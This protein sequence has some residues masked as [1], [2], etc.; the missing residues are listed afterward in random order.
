MAY[1]WL[2]LFEQFSQV[3]VSAPIVL[4]ECVQHFDGRTTTSILYVVG[5]QTIFAGNGTFWVQTGSQTLM[6]QH[7]G[8]SDERFSCS[9][10]FL[11]SA[12]TVH[13]KVL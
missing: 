13:P 2:Q 1:M 9:S 4:R 12:P 5:N 7:N 3:F 6:S 10:A 11:R 8:T